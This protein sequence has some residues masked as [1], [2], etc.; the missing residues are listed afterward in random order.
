MSNLLNKKISKKCFFVVLIGLLII[1]TNIISYKIGEIN[2]KSRC[3][4]LL[5]KNKTKKGKIN[6]NLIKV[7]LFVNPAIVKHR[8]RFRFSYDSPD[9]LYSLR[10][11][12]DLD[13]IVLNSKNRFDL[14]LKLM[15]WTRKQWNP[16][17]PNPYPPI[18]AKVILRLIRTHQ[19]GGFCAQYNYVFVQAVQSFGIKARYITI[20][21]HEVTEVFIKELSKWVCFDPLYAAYYINKNNTPLSVYEIYKRVK[22][23]EK[24]LIISKYKVKNIKTHLN[25][26][27]NFSV[28]LKN[29]HISSPINF[30]DIEYYK[31]YYYEQIDELPAY[32]FF[33]HL[34][35]SSLKD[36]YYIPK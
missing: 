15:F 14:V 4:L 9:I 2:I 18:N 1:L 17:I 23:N 6:K 12:E 16:S 3:L 36:L 11:D 22:G 29:D 10:K 25:K 27:K 32:V 31:V 28:W 8:S 30:K 33:K 35:T 26:F 7:P 21:H 24:I 13:K 5:K 34:T 20:N 19:T